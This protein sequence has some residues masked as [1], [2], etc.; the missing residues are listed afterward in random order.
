MMSKNIEPRMTLMIPVAAFYERRNP[1]VAVFGNPVTEAN[2]RMD[3]FVDCS[4]QFA[5]PVC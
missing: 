5:A 1:A 3:S 4:G 2:E